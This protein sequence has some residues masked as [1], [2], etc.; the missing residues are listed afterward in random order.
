[1]SVE[2]GSESL[3]LLHDQ[4]IP[5]RYKQDFSYRCY[6][7]KFRVCGLALVGG[8]LLLLSMVI[9]LFL[10]LRNSAFELPAWKLGE[11]SDPITV[12]GPGPERDLKFMLHPEEHVSRDPCIRKFS[13][14][15]TKETIAPNGVEKNVFLINDQFPGPT[16]EARSGD[17]LEIE[18]FNHSE[19]SVSLHWHGLHMR[20]ANHMDGPVGINQCAIK[21]GKMFTYRVPTDDQA[22]TFWYHGHSEVQTADGLY[23]GLVIHNPITP[24]ENLYEK[25]L[26][27][28]VGDWY[29]WPSKKVL[30]NFMDRSSTGSEPCPDSLL[31]NGLG[32]FECSMA[33]HGAPVICSDIVKPSLSINKQTHY[34][35]RLV[36]VGSLS[37]FSFTIPDSEMKIV[38]VDGGQQIAEN[39]HPANSVGVL[40]PAERVDFI[41]TWSKSAANTDTEIIIELDKEYFL[42]PNFALTPTQSFLLSPESVKTQP[43]TTNFSIQKFNLREAKGLSLP[44][45]IPAAQKAFMIYTAIEI[46]N[47]EHQI[48]KGFINHTTWEPQ[49]LPLVALDRE[50]WDKHQLVPWTGPEP[51]WVELTINNIDANGHPFH[52]HGYDFYV[53]ASYEGLGGWDY[54]NPFNPSRLPRGGPFNLVNPL[55]K[56]TVYVPPWG[57]VV[58]RFKANNEG[59]WILHCHVL[60]HQ[61]AGMAMAFQVGGDESRGFSDSIFGKSAEEFCRS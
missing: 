44:N 7:Q 33:T 61:A 48:P 55:C 13:W 56:D 51:V 23:G 45:A 57:Y 6:K 35:V 42:R 8:F 17:I 26:L 27:F 14:N 34:R 15:I 36:N 30:A 2:D 59:I 1:M 37:G 10:L 5:K 18:V 29:H 11:H 52:L 32:Q 50:I 24:L 46:L 47:K 3:L 19:E 43:P 39:D 60:W 58:I 38:Q 9:F 25:D 22:G 31:I 21:P 20:G 4:P 49:S 40:Y 41:L 12:T 54:Y 53:L 16:I 28:L